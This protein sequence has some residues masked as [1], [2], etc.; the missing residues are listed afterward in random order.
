MTD[1]LT[2]IAREQERA[3][4]ATDEIAALAA[5]LKDRRRRLTPGATAAIRQ[6]LGAKADAVTALAALRA[7]D[8]PTWIRLL[9]AIEWPERHGLQRLSPFKDDAVVVAQS[10]GWGITGL[11]GNAVTFLEAVCALPGVRSHRQVV[12]SMATDYF[13]AVPRPAK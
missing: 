5:C 8:E 9:M 12:S 2:E 4:E 13:I 7:G 1:A 3:E 6:T 10:R 11:E